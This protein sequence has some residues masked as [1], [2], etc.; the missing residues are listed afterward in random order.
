M[1]Q[2]IRSLFVHSGFGDSLRLS[3]WLAYRFSEELILFFVLFTEAFG[4][5]LIQ[6]FSGLSSFRNDLTESEQII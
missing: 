3:L 2:E 5:T 4:Q 6:P 1:G